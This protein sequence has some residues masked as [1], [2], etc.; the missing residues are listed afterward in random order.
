MKKKKQNKGIKIFAA[1]LLVLGM[2]VTGLMGW[3][4]VRDNKLGNFGGRVELHV[5]PGMTPQDVISQIEEKTTINRKAALL[6]VFEEKQVA[7]YIHPGYYLI[8]STTPSVMLAR[9]LNNGWE[10][11]SK[12][13]LSGTMRL[14]DDIA[15]KIASQMMVTKEEVRA[16]LDDKDFLA[17]YGFTPQNVFSLI[18]PDTYSIFWS[19]SLDQIFETLK[20]AYD[21]Y[22]TEDKLMRAAKLG[23]TREEVSILASIV[24]GESNHEPEQPKIAGVYLN[25]LKEGMKLQADPTVAYCFDYTLTRIL[26]RH[27]QVDSPYNTYKYEGLPPGP[28]CVPSKSCLNAVLDPDTKDGYLYFCANSDWSATHVFARTLSEHNANARAFQAELTRRQREKKKAG[29]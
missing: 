21:A 25:R 18:L 7:T 8:H 26:N 13:T 14:K 29:N 9:M 12:L 2:L 22:W 3:K 16:A 20:K 15:R 17:K 4:Y 11:P 28:I 6:K 24:Q 27:L 10:A 19:A 23:L 5:Y 1:F